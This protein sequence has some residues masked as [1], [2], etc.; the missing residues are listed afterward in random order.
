MKIPKIK[1]PANVTRALYRTGF[2]IKKASPEILVGAG[3]VGGIATVV[4]ACKATVKATEIL[5]EAKHTVD[6]IHSVAESEQFRDS[7]TEEDLEKDLMI[8]R[9]QT[10]VKLV[11]AYAPAVAMGIFSIGCSL[12]GHRIISQRYAG[13]T[14]AY[15]AI[16]KGFK[17]YR[18]R[19]IDRFGEDLDKELRYNIK[20]QEIDEIVTHEDGTTEIVKSTVNVADPNAISDYAFFFDESCLAWTRDAETNFMIAKNSQAQLNDKFQRQG[21]LY[22]NDV[23]DAFGLPRTKAGQVVGWLLGGPDNDGYIDLGIFNPDSER[24]RAFVN[25]YEKNLMIEPNVDGNIWDQM[26]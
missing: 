7:Y 12:G 9:V 14:A 17:D 4:M 2:K 23:R 22:L 5:E 18:G 26:V 15:A 1:I 19:L 20:A 3:I 11:K 24:A 16:D 8:A 21:Y 10:G 6:A 13:L 25:G